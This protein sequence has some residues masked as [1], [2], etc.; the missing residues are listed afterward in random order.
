MGCPTRKLSV[1]IPSLPTRR[2]SVLREL[3]SR[4]GCLGLATLLAIEWPTRGGRHDAYLALAGALL[5][6]GYGDTRRVSP[7]WKEFAPGIIAVIAQ[8]THD[9]A[10]VKTRTE[11][12]VEAH[13]QEK[14]GK[15][16]CREREG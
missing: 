3:S 9:E 7:I 12:S 4:V 16:P 15:A 13:H 2:S 1:H 10:G 14:H 11:Q 6:E 5:A 8:A